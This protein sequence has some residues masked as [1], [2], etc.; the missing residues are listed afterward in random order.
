MIEWEHLSAQ[1]LII[2]ALRDKQYR[3]V[4]EYIEDDV[5]TYVITNKSKVIFWYP[6]ELSNDMAKIEIDYLIENIWSMYNGQH[7]F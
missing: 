4:K 6:F 1:Q 7:D 5:Y 3:I 2:W